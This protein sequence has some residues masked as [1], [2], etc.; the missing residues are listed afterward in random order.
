MKGPHAIEQVNSK[1]LDLQELDTLIES[2]YNLPIGV[3]FQHW[4][5]TIA[6]LFSLVHGLDLQVQGRARLQGP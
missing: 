2:S 6:Q 4:A 1:I 5:I 3:G